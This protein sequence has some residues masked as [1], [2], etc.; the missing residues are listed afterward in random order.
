VHLRN[1]AGRTPLFLAASAGLAE[2]VEL[3]RKS[4]AHLHADERAALA[5]GDESASR[6][7]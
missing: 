3:L 4:G 7:Q 1:S 5:D 6:M 2:H